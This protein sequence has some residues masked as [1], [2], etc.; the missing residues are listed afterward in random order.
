MCFMVKAKVNEL[1]FPVVK[2]TGSR[3][4]YLQGLLKDFY[5]LNIS[6]L[7]TPVYVNIQLALCR[8]LSKM[9]IIIYQLFKTQ[10]YEY[11]AL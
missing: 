10:H 4:L 7:I 5:R 2:A 8:M 6:S 9:P 11:F 1:C 3:T